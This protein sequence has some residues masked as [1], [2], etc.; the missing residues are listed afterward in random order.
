MSNSDLEE[1]SGAEGF[2]GDETLEDYFLSAQKEQGPINRFVSGTFE[3]IRRQYQKAS[4]EFYRLA[5][6]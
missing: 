1:R 3:K 2:F 5:G 4:D 6:W